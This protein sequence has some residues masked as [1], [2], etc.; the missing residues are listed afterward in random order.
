[1]GPRGEK[2]EILHN[3]YTNCLLKMKENKLRSIAFP[4]ISTGVYGY[5]ND[6]A[7]NVALRATKAFLQEYHEVNF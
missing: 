2:P 1:M 7:C 5:P 6:A 3:A 4:C